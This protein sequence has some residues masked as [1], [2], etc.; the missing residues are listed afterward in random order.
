MLLK[1]TEFLCQDFLY[2]KKILLQTRITILYVL[3]VST[4]FRDV[5]IRNY[6]LL[7]ENR[8][9]MQ[10]NVIQVTAV[11]SHPMGEQLRGII[12]KKKKEKG[13]RIYTYL[14]R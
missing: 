5:H 7:Y 10:E 1:R 8:Y 12:S 3:N 14:V 13:T 9:T 2:F 6:V 11:S 4:A